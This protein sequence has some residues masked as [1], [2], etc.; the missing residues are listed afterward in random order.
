MDK[1]QEQLI[2]PQYWRVMYDYLL[3]IGKD[4]YEKLGYCFEE[5]QQILKQKMPADSL[6]AILS[7]TF[8]LS[9]LLEDTRE[10][11]IENQKSRNELARL[12]KVVEVKDKQLETMNDELKDKNAELSRLY[13]LRSYRLATLIRSP[14]TK[15]RKRKK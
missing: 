3:Y 7:R 5:S 4:N 12:R 10:C 14:Y 11:L 15:F 13:N 8:S 2:N 9:S 1:W 6:E